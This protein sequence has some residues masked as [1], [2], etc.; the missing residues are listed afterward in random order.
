MYER[1]TANQDQ[2]LEFV[3]APALKSHQQWQPT[4]NPRF[5]FT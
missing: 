3:L 5:E 4:E 2:I 1:L